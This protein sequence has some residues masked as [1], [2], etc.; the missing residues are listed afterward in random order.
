MEAADPRIIFVEI[1]DLS[2]KKVGQF[3][4]P[5]SIYSKLIGEIFNNGAKVVGLD[6]MFIDPSTPKEDKVLIETAKK[7]GKRLVFAVGF[8]PS[9]INEVSSKYPFP[10]L[11]SAVV[12]LGSVYQSPDPADGQVRLTQLFVGR[13]FSERSEWALSPERIPNLGVKVLSLFEGVD[14]DTYYKRVKE[15]QIRLNIR[16]REKLSVGYTTD[17]RGDVQPVEK[18]AYGIQRL[19]AWK[20]IEGKLDD[21]EKKKLNGSMVI[22][23][24]SAIGAYDHYPTVFD[25][26]SPGAEVYAN[27]ID[28]LIHQRYF[29]DLP[30]YISLL[31]ILFVSILAYWAMRLRMILSTFCFAGTLAAWVAIAIVAFHRLVILDFT[32]VTLAIIGSFGVLLIHRALLEE[33]QKREVRQ[34]FGQYVSPEIVDVLVKDPSKIRLGGDRRNMTVLFLDIAHFTTISE[35]MKPEDLIKFLNTYLT[36][37]TDVIHKHNGVVDKYIGDCIMAFWNAPLDFPRHRSLACRAAVECLGEV[38][39]LNEEYVDPSIPELAVRIGLNS[40]DVVVGNTGSARKLS[41]T[42]LGDDVNLASRLEGANKF[43]GSTAMAS[44][45]TFSEAR[46]VVEGRLLGSI[47]VVGKEIPIKVFELL[48]KKGELSE[49]WK[50]ALPLYEQG[51]DLYLKKD[52]ARAI[53]SFSEVL[54]VFPNDKPGKFYVDVCKRHMESPPEGSW[55]GVFNLTSK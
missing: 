20:A 36:A 55:D 24:S 29:R 30:L 25:E 5:R 51:V 48:A 37:L 2:I 43:F 1:D 15:N 9:V 49:E 4:W 40:G 38:R 54:K 22:L 19:P 52:F 13:K 44:E 14:P 39:R 11:M 34:M 53:E 16:G 50:K 7:Y 3:P 27:L 33:K 21:E 41:Y 28:N 12:S 18:Y 32:G 35:K 26:Q 42:V 45:D 10:A 46:E 6:I 47:R 23:A 31:I 17:A 8:D